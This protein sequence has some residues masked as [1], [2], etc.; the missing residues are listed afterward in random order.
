MYKCTRS[1]CFRRKYS[2]YYVDHY[3]Q[4]LLYDMHLHCRNNKSTESPVGTRDIPTAVVVDVT[5]R[6]HMIHID[7]EVDVPV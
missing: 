4:F 5:I 2:C 7:V 6:L 3:R 1:F